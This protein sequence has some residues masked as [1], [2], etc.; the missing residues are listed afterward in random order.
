VDSVRR[1]LDGGLDGK[2]GC[3]G[4]EACEGSPRF[5]VV[6]CVRFSLADAGD[7]AVVP[8]RRFKKFMLDFD[9]RLLPNSTHR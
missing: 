8:K 1:W 5:G 7:F 2:V 4:E 6:G 9:L 3:A